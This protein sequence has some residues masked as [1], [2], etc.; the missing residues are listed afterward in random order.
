MDYASFRGMLVMAGVRADAGQGNPH[1]I[2][3][4]DGKVALWVGA[5]DD[6]WKLGRPRGQGG[7]WK[8]SAVK[9]GQISDPY[10]LSHYE[11]R[12]LTLRHG[13]DQPV[14]IRVELDPTGHGPWVT[15]KTFTVPPGK[16]I[17][18]VF[19]AALHA[20]WIRFTAD[21]DTTATAWLVYE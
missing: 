13:T 21:R 1:I 11:R 16:S 20:R 15:Y 17:D 18:H 14:T 19:P 8:D 12:T 9:T 5:I 4:D 2:R 7:P 10:L 6:L 3:S